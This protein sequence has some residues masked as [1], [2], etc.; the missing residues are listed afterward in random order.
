V[1]RELGF[2]EAGE[3]A[4][5]PTS[6]DR[7]EYVYSNHPLFRPFASPDYGN[8]LEV[9][10][11]QYRRLNVVEGIP[12]L[13]S[14]TGDVLFSQGT[15]FPGRLFVAAF[16]CEREHTSWPLH[17]TFV[18]FLDLCLQQA[19]P[20]DPTPLNQEPGTTLAL[21][22]PQ[23][24]PAR[25]LVL[26]RRRDGAV[27]DRVPVREGRAQLTLP[28]T[29]GLY[30]VT[31]DDRNPPDQILSVNPHPKESDLRYTRPE[32]TLELWEAKGRRSPVET[33]AVATTVDRAQAYEQKVWW[34]LLL[35]G[36][37]GLVL[38]TSWTA[39]RARSP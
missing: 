1:L 6:P 10:M 38:E 18:P 8:L 4:S 16:G 22:L 13:F 39:W 33:V 26:R 21:Q 36:S 7:I 3:V 15:R 12:L 17:V 5:D 27:V 37:L 30:A 28:D 2:E 25:E 20:T 31:R 14:R 11:P 9:T 29:P 24:R 35:A 32:A 34:W 19:R 23:H